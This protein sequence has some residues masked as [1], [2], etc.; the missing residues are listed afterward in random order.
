MTIFNFIGIDYD[1]DMPLP[2]FAAKLG[3]EKGFRVTGDAF[4][5]NILS[6]T[7]EPLKKNISAQEVI[8]S[9]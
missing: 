4:K 2:E 6:E 5:K 8:D 1:G 9:C 7:S 3:A